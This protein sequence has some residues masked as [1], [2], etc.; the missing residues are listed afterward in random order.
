MLLAQLTDTHIVNPDG[1]QET[2]VDNNARLALAVA[3]LNEETV[4]PEVVL[5]AYQSRPAPAAV[6][7]EPETEVAPLLFLT[8]ISHKIAM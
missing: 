5:A 7:S 1:D 2:V 8:Y 3:R 6:E 4:Q